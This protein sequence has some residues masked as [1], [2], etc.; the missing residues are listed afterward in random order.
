[1]K[2]WGSMDIP[3]QITQRRYGAGSIY[4]GQPIY[5]KTDGD[6]EVLYPAYST[7]AALL[8]S[9]GLQEDFSAST[10]ALRYTHRRTSQRD[11]YFVSNRTDQPVNAT[12]SF[13]VK[14]M[15]P[16]LWHP[17]TGKRR[18][19]PDYMAGRDGTTVPLVFAPYESYF[20]VFSDPA[21][22]DKSGGKNFP[23]QKAI[24]ALDGSWQVTFD[25]ERGGPGSV[26]FDRLQDW[27]QHSERGIQYYSG[28]AAYSKQ[29]DMPRGADLN[30]LWIDLGTTYEM[31][32]VFLNGVEL[33]TAWTA[34]W[35][36]S[37]G[38]VLKARGNELK[39]VVANSWENRLIGDESADGKDVRTLQWDS[40]LLG[41]KP[42]K[43]GPYTFTTYSEKA[44]ELQPSGLIGPVR[45]VHKPSE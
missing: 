32:K 20:V 44:S 22:G 41:G 37:A 24:L 8:Q 16:E 13:R 21:V 28:T 5:T 7:T 40:G 11:I 18:E 26:T 6:E 10:S 43:T 42:Y 38:D 4:W 1:M 30:S 34:P 33:G 3:E 2:L 23:E 39:V 17:E 15:Q 19:L 14:G 36:V 35:Q 45:I 9:M 31:A 27:S 29:F 12:A 25:P